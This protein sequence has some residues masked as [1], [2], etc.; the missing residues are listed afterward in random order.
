MAKQASKAPE[1]S[2]HPKADA[3]RVQELSTPQLD[4]DESPT[5]PSLREAENPSWHD[6]F[7]PAEH[8]VRQKLLEKAKMNKSASSSIEPAGAPQSYTA[9]VDATTLV[10][11]KPSEAAPATSNLPE[12]QASTPKEPQSRETPMKTLPPRRSHSPTLDLASQAHSFHTPLPPAAEV[13]QE[14][15]K[16]VDQNRIL[17]QGTGLSLNSKRAFGALVGLGLLFGLGEITQSDFEFRDK[18][19]TVSG[20]EAAQPE[21]TEKS[22]PD[23]E[24]AEASRKKLQGPWRIDPL[25]KSSDQKVISGRI[26]KEPFLKAIQTAGL[27]KTQAYRAYTALKDIKNLDRCRSRDQF[28]AL[29]EGAQ[30]R[31]VA[32]EYIV[33]KEEIY[34][35]KTDDSNLLRGKKLDLIVERSQVRRAF[36]HSG[37]SFDDSA[38]AFGFDPGLAN[39]AQK[40]LRGHMLLGEFR[41]GDRLRVIAQEVTVL[42]D[43][44]RYAGIEAMEVAR[45]S[46]KKTLRIYY[47][48]HPTVGG[49]YDRTGRAPYDGGWRK[50]IPDAPVTSKFNMKR[51]HPVLKRIHPHTGTDFGAPTGTPIHATAPGV[52][53]FIGNGG[54]SGNLVKIRHEG[55]YE[56][57][58]AHLS[59]FEKG[60]K[61]GAKVD[62][63]Q[64]VGYCGSTGRSTG[65]HLH[66]TIKK[67]GKYID[68][69]TLNLDGLRVLPKSYRNDFSAVRKKYDPILDQIA[70]PVISQ[71]PVAPVQQPAQVAVQNP[72]GKPTPA[73][74]P[75]AQPAQPA[76]SVPVRATTS[77]PSG[78]AK[79]VEASAIFLSDA[80]LIK[81]QS[82][83]DDGEVNP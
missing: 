1:Q 61:V 71:P 58:Y 60:L 66:F 24:A 47:F 63:M 52:V 55:G 45:K 36:T 79:R 50:P 31:L 4:L 73:A 10:A 7:A 53:S 29:V 35:A 28:V 12:P 37:K 17:P 51:M 57:G 6:S 21:T 67:N 69:E 8:P 3:Q 30:Q 65:P 32:F 26:G 16:I 59:R 49:Y 62:R 74:A 11:P 56:S 13:A 5:P 44:S 25:K 18:A 75:V 76:R 14:L 27:D 70:W 20:P 39:V 81:M 34:Q 42:G 46:K 33:S 40:A 77:V 15:D 72:A 80:E 38:S 83:D 23:S 41:K 64:P 48:N 19:P 78:P 68:A 22:K 9:P 2:E 43:F 54:A 82:N